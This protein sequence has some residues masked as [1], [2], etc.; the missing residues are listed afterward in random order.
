[1]TQKVS[2]SVNLHEKFDQ[3]PIIAMLVLV[4]SKS[5]ESS[6]HLLSEN[7]RRF[8]PTEEEILESEVTH[9][10][11]RSLNPLINNINLFDNNHDNEILK[12]II[13]CL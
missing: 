7:R 4:G 9:F 5:S 13:M 11:S 6:F 8:I 10:E 12:I 1:M 2:D 3:Q